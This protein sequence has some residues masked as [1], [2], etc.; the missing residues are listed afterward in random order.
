MSALCR[1]AKLVFPRQVRRWR[2]SSARIYAEHRHA[3]LHLMKRKL[4]GVR[5]MSPLL[6]LRRDR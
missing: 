3:A 4:F 1:F 2:A 5:V 6:A